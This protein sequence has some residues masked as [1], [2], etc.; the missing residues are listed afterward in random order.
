MS[1]KKYNPKDFEVVEVNKENFK[2]SV[3]ERSNMKN[4]FTLADIEAAQME[5]R[6]LQKEVTGQKGVC[7]A[8]CD[9][10]L[11]NHK[12]VGD[13]SEEQTHH[14][15]MYQE[16]KVVLDESV[17]KLKQIEEQLDE[18]DKLSDTI[19]KVGGFVKSEE[20]VIVEPSELK[21]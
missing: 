17:A 8:T 15:W 18:Y 10:I 11:K 14:V 6:R 1:D 12:F 3:I 21:G 4:K 7:Q 5:M 19:Y 13:L 9:N 20:A 16:N 2:L